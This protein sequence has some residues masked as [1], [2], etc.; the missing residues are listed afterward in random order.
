MLRASAG[1]ILTRWSFGFRTVK[2]AWSNDSSAPELMNVDLHEV[3]VVA[4]P[5]Y[6]DT[7]AAV[8]SLAEWDHWPSNAAGWHWRW[9]KQNRP[10]AVCVPFPHPTLD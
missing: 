2:D 7:S 5:A 4:F 3:S 6:P 1:A 9:S 8:R 10:A